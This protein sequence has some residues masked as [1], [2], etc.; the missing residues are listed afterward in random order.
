MAIYIADILLTSACGCK[1]K[2]SEINISL[3]YV[4]VSFY[5]MMWTTG[6]LL[7]RHKVKGMSRCE[8]DN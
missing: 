1:I 4:K 2:E 8:Y 6:T 3:G 7:F 5:Y